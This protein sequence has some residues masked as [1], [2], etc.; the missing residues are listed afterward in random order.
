MSAGLLPRWQLRDDAIRMVAWRPSELAKLAAALE[1]AVLAWALD[2]GLPSQGQVRCEAETHGR[3]S[4]G[5]QALG[6]AGDSRSWAKVDPDCESQLARELLGTG[7]PLTALAAE[8]LRACRTDLRMRLA[9][10]CSVAAEADACSDGPPP[11]SCWSGCVVA[12]LPFGLRMWLPR[13]CVATLVGPA[14]ALAASKRRPPEL[15]PVSDAV[16][17]APIPLQVKLRPCQMDMGSLFDLRVGDVVGLQH[18]IVEPVAIE[19]AHGLQVFRGHLA[20]ARGSK[21]VE[22]APSST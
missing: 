13:R 22:L 17:E 1:A 16:A 2:W 5:W 14:A 18:A 19:D 11:S 21:A 4:D 10:A 7:D 12:S 20:R 15:F 6:G 8:V 9:T 3:D